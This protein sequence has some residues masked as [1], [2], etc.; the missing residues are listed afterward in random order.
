M[1]SDFHL[2]WHLQLQLRVDRA[3]IVYR[4][5]SSLYCYF[6]LFLEEQCP[7]SQSDWL[8]FLDEFLSLCKS[9]HP[10]WA[11]LTPSCSHTFTSNR[12]PSVE[13]MSSTNDAADRS[14]NFQAILNAALAKYLEHTGRDLLNDPLAVEIQRCKSPDD[15]LSVFKKQVE[16]FDEFKKADS[17]L[18]RYIDPIVNG[19]FSLFTNATLSAAVSLVSRKEFTES[20]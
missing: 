10:S 17:K 14:L 19:L 4:E 1:D 9:T 12:F 18:M 6:Y 3:S 5:I 11:R 20:R 7:S 13:P 8:L 2:L 15:I 16:K